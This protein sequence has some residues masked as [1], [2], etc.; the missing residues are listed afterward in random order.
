MDVVERGA[1]GY[2]KRQADG[3]AKGKTQK[4][5]VASGMP[6]VIYS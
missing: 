5:I 2:A 1:S 3:K 6:R 4:A